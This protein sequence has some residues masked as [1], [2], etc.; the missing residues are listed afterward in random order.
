M[1]IPFRSVGA[2]SALLVAALGTAT[3]SAQPPI[4]T[5]WDWCQRVPVSHPPARSF[6]AFAAGPLTGNN[7]QIAVLFGGQDQNGVQLGDTWEWDGSTWW[8]NTNPTQILPLTHTAIGL[9]PNALIGVLFGGRDLAGA[10]TAQ[11][12]SYEFPPSRQFRA[13]QQLFPAT[14][15]PARADHAMAPSGSGMIMFGGMGASGA[16]ADTWTYDHRGR[17]WVQLTPS[18]SPPARYGHR[19]AY[20]AVR[21]R[22]VLFGG[23]AANGTLLNDT[24][25]WDG[26]NWTQASPSITPPAR[27]DHAMCS[28]VVG[29]QTLVLIHGGDG[30]SGQLADAWQFDGIDWFPVISSSDPGPRVGHQLAEMALGL[31]ATSFGGSTTGPSTADSTWSLEGFPALTPPTSPLVCSVATGCGS[32]PTLPSITTD[33]VPLQDPMVSTPMLFE[34]R[35]LPAAPTPMG[36]LGAFVF[37]LIGGPVPCNPSFPPLQASPDYVLPFAYSGDAAQINYSIPSTPNL[38]GANLYHQVLALLPTTSLAWV[39]SNVVRV[40]IGQ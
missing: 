17:T 26:T 5:Q 29:S 32:T 15:P 25:E 30:A 23:H 10:V 3:L 40:R 12:W 35:D 8:E 20:D 4:P 11:T 7:E 22:V 2:T 27:A 33:D 9:D 24:W 21:D 6:A 34:L 19:M 13:F 18:Q 37:G 16:L 28:I 36:G 31:R 14:V 38:V 1:H 39:S